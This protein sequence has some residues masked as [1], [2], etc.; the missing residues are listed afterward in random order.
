MSG[1]M[2]SFRLMPVRSSRGRV[3]VRRENAHRL[4]SAELLH[5]ALMFL[6]VHDTVQFHIVHLSDEHT[7]FTDKLL[8]ADVVV[9]PAQ[10]DEAVQQDKR[11]EKE[12]S[13]PGN[14]VWHAF[15]AA[16]DATGTAHGKGRQLV[17]DELHLVWSQY[18]TFRL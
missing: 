6:E 2:S 17:D 4:Q 8:D 9:Y 14:R 7:L 12:D 3:P 5:Q 16:V 1:T 10:V 11:Q 18:E 15:H 13:N